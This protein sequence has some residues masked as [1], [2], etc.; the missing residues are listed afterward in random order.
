[1]SIILPKNNHVQLIG[2][3]ELDHFRFRFMHN[4][5]EVCLLPDWHNT[6]KF[7]CENNQC[8]HAEAE[9]KKQIEFVR[10]LKY[11]VDCTSDDV[12][13]GIKTIFKSVRKHSGCLLLSNWFIH[14]GANATTCIDLF[15]ETNPSSRSFLSGIEDARL[16]TLGG[17]FAFC[18]KKEIGRASE[19]N[20]QRCRDI[21]PNARFHGVDSRS[22]NTWLVE[23]FPKEFAKQ[24]N[25]KGKT[26]TID[27]LWKAINHKHDDLKAL[28]L[29]KEMLNTLQAIDKQFH[30]SLFRE[31]AALFFQAFKF[32]INDEIMSD[33]SQTLSF[34]VEVRL[35]DAYTI[36]RIFNNTWHKKLPTNLQTGN[37]CH[38]PPRNIVLF[39][40]SSH[41]DCFKNFV[42]GL[43]CFINP[44]YHISRKNEKEGQQ[45]NCLPIPFEHLPFQQHVKK[46]LKTTLQITT[47]EEL[48]DFLKHSSK[49]VFEQLCRP[50]YNE[51]WLIR[52][53]N[54]DSKQFDI[55]PDDDTYTS[56]LEKHNL[57]PVPNAV[58]WHTTRYLASLLKDAHFD[59]DFA[60]QIPNEDLEDFIKWKDPSTSAFEWQVRVF[61]SQT[62]VENSTLSL[63]LTVG[64]IPTIWQQYI[65]KDFQNVTELFYV[66]LH[67]KKPPSHRYER[68][69]TTAANLLQSQDKGAKLFIKTKN[70]TSFYKTIRQIY[71][72]LQPLWQSHLVALWALRVLHEYESKIL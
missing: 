51:L 49:D 46:R 58:L 63:V 7:Y 38:G 27:L 21:L 18:G 14:L 5:Y 3:P 44:V 22:Q 48:L 11:D 71:M 10:S 23:T 34:R 36:L 69:K 15:V 12:Q 70:G 55:Q 32:A 35:M 43:G 56:F 47:D 66:C 62:I 20:A 25:T 45:S 41:T 42:L 29:A 13:K 50:K 16:H 68:T 31:H 54:S 52:L 67:E 61:L 17:L 19:I 64:A 9:I 59:Q 60:M 37:V 40:G 72:F 30:K 2:V 57:Q 28:R 65:P 8:A 24:N 53:T 26:V 33:S 1:M 6:S 39:A 4:N